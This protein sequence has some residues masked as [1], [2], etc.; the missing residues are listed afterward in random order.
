[1]LQ[2]SKF[3]E[4]LR[5]SWRELHE[6]GKIA[7]GIVLPKIS[8][9]SPWPGGG[10]GGLDEIDTCISKPS[11]CK[12]GH[13]PTSVD[14]VQSMQVFK[15]CGI[16]WI[17]K[18]LSIKMISSVVQLVRLCQGSP[19]HQQVGLFQEKRGTA[20]KFRGRKTLW[21]WSLSLLRRLFVVS[22]CRFRPRSRSS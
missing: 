22:A 6:K 14:Q 17:T 21:D 10:G 3:W 12:V 7:L 9:L 4:D 15:K 16:L 2:F 5:L 18:Q 13:R 20:V 19:A 8:E 1:M 11:S